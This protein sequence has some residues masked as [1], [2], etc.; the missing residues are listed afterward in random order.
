MYSIGDCWKFGGEIDDVTITQNINRVAHVGTGNYSS[1][2]MDD[3]NY[4]SGSLSAMI[5][6]V[7]CT[8][9]KYKDTVDMVKAWREFITKNSVFMLKSQK[10]DVW[11]VNITESPS[12]TYSEMERD[13]PTT[14]QFNWAECM[15]LK[16][17]LIKQ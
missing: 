3:V 14:F 8:D 15:D 16:K 12:T 7:D 11:I 6:A 2:S 5:G 13:I 9:K 10:G 1:V 4:A 17:V